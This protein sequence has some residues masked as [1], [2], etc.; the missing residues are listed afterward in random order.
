MRWTTFT[1]F[2]CLYLGIFLFVQRQ[3]LP[4][5]P[6]FYSKVVDL[7]EARTAITATMR[8]KQVPPERLVVPAIVLN[9]RGKVAMKDLAGYERAHGAIPQGAVVFARSS[10][11]CL[12]FAAEVMDFLVAARNISGVASSGNC[13]RLSS[14][15]SATEHLYA[16]TNVTGLEALPASGATAIIAPMKSIHD[17][18]VAVRILA[19]VQ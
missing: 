14:R 15:R 17:G 4:D 1:I 7:T 5:R 3:P 11:S 10:T 2:C 12:E 8:G 16:L 6:Y 18:P 13:L 19:L 9:A